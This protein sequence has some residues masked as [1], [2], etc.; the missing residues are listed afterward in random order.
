MSDD[1][2]KFEKELHTK[3]W[4]VLKTP[5]GDRLA[6]VFRIQGDTMWQIQLFCDEYARD[7]AKTRLKAQEK[8][9]RR[10]RKIRSSLKN[11]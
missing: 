7:H 1:T 5:E 6:N 3:N 8:A 2:L 4:Y 10:L 9:R 11:V